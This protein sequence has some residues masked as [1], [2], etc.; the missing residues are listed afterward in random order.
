MPNIL[1][2]IDP[3]ETDNRAL[4]RIEEIP[5]ESATYKIDYYLQSPSSAENSLGMSKKLEEKRVWLE[6]LVKPYEDKG[7][8]IK[9]EVHMFHDLYESIIKSALTW[10]ADIIF[11]P[12]RR[13]STL[14]KLL[15]TPTDWHL[16]RECPCPLLFVTHANSIKGSPLIAAVDIASKDSAHNEL[17][18]VVLTQSKRLAAVLGSD[19]HI[20]HAYQNVA[21]TSQVAISDPLAN[22]PANERRKKQFSTAYDL[23]QKNDVLHGNVH[24]GE[25]SPELV[26][27]RC[28]SEIGASIVV[29]GTVA[30]TGAAGLIIGNT[31]ESVLE[32]ARSDVFVVKQPEFVSPVK[33]A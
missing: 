10:G 5:P 8:V 30:R 26:V 6:E 31:A 11:K 24:L 20:V 23:A 22:L 13:H 33:V 25:G 29:I 1:I 19:V 27:N 9:K 18:D 14:K 4:K 7:Y 12:L 32:N 28:A 3:D 17:N 15:F 21:V 2:V 16:V